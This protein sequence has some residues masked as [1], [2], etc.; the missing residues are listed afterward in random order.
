M[1]TRGTGLSRWVLGCLCA[2]VLAAAPARLRAQP[3]PDVTLSAVIASG[4][5]LPVGLVNAGDGTGRLFVVQQR[6]KIL[7]YS[8]AYQLLGTV[9]D[10]SSLT[11]CGDP[12][13]GC[14]EQGLL[15]LA[16]HPDYASNGYF[17]V[18][19]TDANGDEVIARYKVSANPNVANPASAAILLTVPDP[20]PNHNGGQLQFGPDGYLYV[21]MGDGGAGGDPGNR[22]Q[23]P[24]ELLGKILR[25]D[26]DATGAVPCGQSQPAPYA[27]PADNPFAGSATACN[28]VWDYGLRNP[29][30][31]SFDRANGDLWIGDVGQNLYEEVD[32]EPSGGSG[33]VNYGWRRMEGFHCYDPPTGCNNGGLQ[34]PILELPHS[35]ECS[36]TGG[37]VYRGRLSPQLYGVYIFG[38]YCSGKVWGVTRDS[39][40]NWSRRQIASSQF[41][42]SFGQDEAGELY[43]VEHSGAV[44]RIIGPTSYA[45]PAIA[46]LTPFAAVKGDPSFTLTVDGT[47]FTPASLVRWN[48]SARATTYVSRT[49]L[50]M[51]VAA[52]DV[53]AT[54]SATLTVSNPSP[55]GGISAGKSFAVTNMFL[56]VP[57]GYLLRRPIE[58]I[59]DA[60]IT[61]G[62]GARLFCPEVAVTRDQM[63]V[64]LL[65]AEHGSGYA[66]PAASG[67]VFGDV[68]KG[69]FASAFIEQLSTEGI[70]AGCGSGNY[71]PTVPVTRAP[72]AKFL[73]KAHDGGSY[74]PSQPPTG[75]FS[76][77]S[78]TDPFAAFIEELSRRGITSGC[79]GGK[80]CPNQNVTRAQMAAFLARAF[81][82]PLAP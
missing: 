19:Y 63:A 60:G 68:A 81:S 67:T 72:M 80:Y 76:D 12:A 46:A 57:I 73:L 30:R 61:E 51:T 29:W 18:D 10:I 52:S 38:D 33:G 55:G 79:G 7:A 59:A 56:D 2:L 20:F 4:L 41:I 48:G 77:V 24:G 69:D 82:I 65:R 8:A 32:Y 43:V 70:T 58:G 11:T 66:P 31:F 14:G 23:N 25:I 15:G 1:R 49:R 44:R 37:Y 40:G 50:T 6:G 64:L 26:V 36:V 17:F 21:A 13:I 39:A 78:P 74:V 35:P 75:I 53:A 3:A 62:C 22:A 16:F 47:G 71:C 54:G 27:I 45:L 9:L 42:S 34:L 5:T 28:E